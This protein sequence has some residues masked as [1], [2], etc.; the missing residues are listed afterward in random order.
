MATLS[1]VSSILIGMWCQ[2][3]VTVPVYCV[4]QNSRLPFSLLYSCF[5]V[6]FANGKQVPGMQS[7]QQILHILG[8]KLALFEIICIPSTLNLWIRNLYAVCLKIVHLGAKSQ[9]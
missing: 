1:I 9:K 3:I 4:T 2:L 5:A 6:V 8:D 7:H